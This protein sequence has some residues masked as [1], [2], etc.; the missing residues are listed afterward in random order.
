MKK[1]ANKSKAGKA[2]KRSSAKR[3]GKNQSATEADRR[4]QAYFLETLE[5]NKQVSRQRG[6]LPP[7]ATH[8]AECGKSGKERIVRK[9]FS[10]L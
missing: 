10:A 5:A 2:T 1:A 6:P 3:A 4:E 7:G 8:Q 9:R